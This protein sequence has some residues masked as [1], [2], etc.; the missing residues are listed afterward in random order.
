M[1]V[2]LGVNLCSNCVSGPRGELVL[3]VLVD[4]CE[5]VLTAGGPR[6]ELVLTASGPRCELVLTVLVYLDV[7]SF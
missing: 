2:D 5:L 3:T 4:L 6:C 1:L 7:N